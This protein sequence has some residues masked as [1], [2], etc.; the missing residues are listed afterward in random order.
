MNFGRLG[1][2]EEWEKASDELQHCRHR[3]RTCGSN[4]AAK[5]HV[6][7]AGKQA[8]KLKRIE[9][10]RPSDLNRNSDH[11][12]YP[13]LLSPNNRQPNNNHN[14]CAGNRQSRSFTPARRHR[15][16]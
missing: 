10:K 11:V 3:T 6:Q 9:D 2:H 1:R 16:R 7:V 12:Y 5:S 8:L 14:L 13:A 4:E 15:S